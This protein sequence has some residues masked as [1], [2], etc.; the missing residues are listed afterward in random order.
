MHSQLGKT[1]PV[2]IGAL[3]LLGAADP[4]STTINSK[5][6]T[7]T[8]ASKQQAEATTSKTTT[9]AR[10]YEDVEQLVDNVKQLEGQKV[11][12]PGE[13]KQ[14]LNPRAFVLESGGIINDEIVVLVPK[15]LDEQ[16]VMSI[17][18][19]A[20]LAVTGVV[21]NVPL[22]EVRRELG[23]DMDPQLVVELE[24]VKSYIVADRIA[25]R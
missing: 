24:R 20:D 25:Q 6:K 16:Q 9:P 14:L 12:V 10:Q 17:K 21:R 3:F 1:V 4:A 23:W 15:K 5:E 22:I 8:D 2:V 13:V 11:S 7:G 19:D 18:D